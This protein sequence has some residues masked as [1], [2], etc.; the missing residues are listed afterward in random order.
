[1]EKEFVSPSKQISQFSKSVHL[2]C[3]SSLI[4]N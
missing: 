1:M 4:M 3:Y 2:F